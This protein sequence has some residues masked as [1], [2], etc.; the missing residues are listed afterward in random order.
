MSVQTWVIH[1]KEDRPRESGHCL[2]PNEPETEDIMSGKPDLFLPKLEQ[3]TSLFHYS[4]YHPTT[5]PPLHWG[6]QLCTLFPS[7]SK[8]LLN[9]SPKFSSYDFIETSRA[10][11]T[12]EYVKLSGQFFSLYFNL[13]SSCLDKVSHSH[14]FK[15]ISFLALHFTH[16]FWTSLLHPRET[17]FGFS[18]SIVS[19]LWSCLTF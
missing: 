19:L 13:T 7:L 9:S 17:L 3:V 10:K 12:P 8:F 5:S 14:P 6:S 4:C 16:T 2:P 15:A 11:V 18:L 1:G